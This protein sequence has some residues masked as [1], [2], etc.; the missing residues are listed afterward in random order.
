MGRSGK[1]LKEALKSYRIRQNKL[2]AALGVDR[3]IVFRWYHEQTDPSGDKI[4]DIVKALKRIEPAAA[5]KFVELYLGE[6]V[7]DEEES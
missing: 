1:A 3:S 5:K 6:L 2:A 7:E 4:V